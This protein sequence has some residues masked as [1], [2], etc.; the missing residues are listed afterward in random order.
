MSTTPKRG[1]ILWDSKFPIIIPLFVLALVSYTLLSNGYA[2]ETGVHLAHLIHEPTPHYVLMLLG[3]WVFFGRLGAEI[4]IDEVLRAGPLVIGAIL[5]GVLV[6]MGLTTGLVYLVGG[7]V[8]LSVALYASA[9]AMAT[10]VPMALG[11]ARSVKKVVTPIMV[12]ALMILAVGDDLLGVLAMT[13]MFAQGWY[14]FDALAVEAAI[15]L[16]CWLVGKRGDL[17][18][19]QVEEGKLKSLGIFDFCIKAPVFWIMVAV[20][21]TYYLGRHGI[22]PILGGCL[23]FIFAPSDVKHLIAEKT[24]ALALW[25][26]IPFAIVAGSVDLLQ[27]QAWGIFTLLAMFGGFGGKVVGIFSGAWIGRKYTNP[28]GDYG[29]E[30]FTNRS[31]LGMAVAGAC[32]GTVAIIFVSVA[33]SKGLI[34]SGMAGQMKIGFLLTVPLSYVTNWLVGKIK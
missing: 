32:N 23:V 25:L 34:P 33:E 24:E 5:G 2:G 20:L 3:L 15:L 13:G 19:K 26:L 17:E 11:S 28:T 12:T 30:Q 21:N 9:G 4:E 10:D 29:A 8:A 14:Q 27:P 6:P 18:I 1:I 31:I 22:E 7:G 16:F